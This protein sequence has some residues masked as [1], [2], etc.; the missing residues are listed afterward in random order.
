M[1]R[2][3]AVKENVDVRVQLQQQLYLNR[4]PSLKNPYH[5]TRN[6]QIIEYKEY[7]QK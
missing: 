4:S 2:E 6:K 7:L 3:I 5:N 1:S